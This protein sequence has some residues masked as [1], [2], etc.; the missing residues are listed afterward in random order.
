[1]VF[2]FIIKDIPCNLRVKTILGKEVN[3][4]LTLR[5]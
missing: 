5:M 4:C 2:R 1:M 3:V